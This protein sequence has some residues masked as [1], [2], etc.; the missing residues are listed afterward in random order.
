MQINEYQPHDQTTLN[1]NKLK[2]VQHL[3]EQLVGLMQSN[4][5][6]TN[7]DV[8]L[9]QINQYQPHSKVH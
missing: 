2:L 9:M 8:Y 1:L 7:V 4:G 3:L 6:L 5:W